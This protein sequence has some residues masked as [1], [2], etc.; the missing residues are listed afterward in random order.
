[1]ANAK[2]AKVKVT[3]RDGVDPIPVEII[4]QDIAAISAAMRKIN[5]TRLTRKAIVVLIQAQSG[6][7]KGVIEVVLN[8][9][10]SL[11]NT[12]LKRKL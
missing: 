6:L 1:M 12:W 5:E 8:N 11:E 7:G 2:T 9:L 4:A 3:Q 10:D